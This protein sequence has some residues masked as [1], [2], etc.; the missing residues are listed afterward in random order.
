[1]SPPLIGKP[2][3]VIIV[4]IIAVIT[5]SY[6][7]RRCRCIVPDLTTELGGESHE[8][9]K[10]CSAE[11]RKSKSSHHGLHHFDFNKVRLRGGLALD[12]SCEH[13]RCGFGGRYSS[14]MVEFT[15]VENLIAA[16]I[17]IEA[18]AGTLIA[19]NQIP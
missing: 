13:C 6:N 8:G 15:D 14:L 7:A 2:F 1:M 19:G 4:I 18:T 5:R 17:P 3:T 10:L 9:R 12:Q 16:G 11:Q